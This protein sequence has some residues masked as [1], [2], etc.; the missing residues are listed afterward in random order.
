MNPM[1]GPV[2][3]QGRPARRS[4][5]PYLAL[6][7]LGGICLAATVAFTGLALDL[8][9]YGTAGGVGSGDMEG[10]GFMFMIALCP[11]GM[12]LLFVTSGL[13]SLLRT[14][15]PRPPAPS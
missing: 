9:G 14:K 4:Y 12:A 3:G 5:R 15:V 1:P 7:I 8:A 10:A 11:G 2:A 6:F 13:V